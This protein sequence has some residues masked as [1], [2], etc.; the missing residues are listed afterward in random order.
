MLKGK[1]LELQYLADGKALKKSN[2]T[3]FN[4]T[5]AIS[6]IEACLDNEIK[7]LG[8]DGFFV[9]EQYMQ[10]SMNDS[11][12]FTASYAPKDI[13]RYTFLFDFLNT[14]RE[15]MLVFQD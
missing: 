1:E 3:L 12:D 6:F 14:N 8:I 11:F 15:G 2:I 5:N 9:H 4:R 10:P 13:D 7:I